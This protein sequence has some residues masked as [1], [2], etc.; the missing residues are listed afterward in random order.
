MAKIFYELRQNKSCG[1]PSSFFSVFQGTNEIL[2]AQ[3]WS[4]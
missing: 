2:L 4:C 1:E 3:I